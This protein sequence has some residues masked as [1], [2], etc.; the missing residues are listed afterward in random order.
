MFIKNLSIQNVFI[1][2]YTNS[3]LV[4]KLAIWQKITRFIYNLFFHIF[5]LL[6]NHFHIIVMGVWGGGFQLI[7]VNLKWLWVIDQDGCSQKKHTCKVSGNTETQ[8]SFCLPLSF[9]CT[10][11][12]RTVQLC[13]LERS[14][15]LR[16]HKDRIAGWTAQDSWSIRPW[17][18]T[19]QTS[20]PLI[21]APRWPVATM[22][23][24][25]LDLCW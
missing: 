16:S 21:D 17:V 3:H 19:P 22:S 10:C 14:I 6:Y 13:L 2:C 24:L 11:L 25:T 23:R 4:P 1:H 12:A 7:S 8:S 18:A 9:C 15:L 5:Y 20:L